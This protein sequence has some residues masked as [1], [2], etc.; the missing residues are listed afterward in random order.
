MSLLISSRSC[1]LFVVVL[2]V[3][4]YI[5]I[6]NSFTLMT[7]GDLLNRFDDGR[8]YNQNNFALLNNFAP[9]DQEYSNIDIPIAQGS[10]PSDVEGMFLRIGPNPLPG[11]QHTSRRYHWFDGHGMIHSMRI[12]HDQ[13]SGIGKASY[14]NQWVNTPRYAIEKKYDRP[15]F[16]MIGEMKGIIGIIKV[17]LLSPLITNIFGLTQLTTG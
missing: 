2:S 11:S 12:Y 13:E 9:V 16:V 15:I 1:I 6:H 10:V 14:S 5:V 4:F 8:E 3:F 7:I 17:A